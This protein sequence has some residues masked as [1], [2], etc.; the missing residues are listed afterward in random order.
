MKT[1]EVYVIDIFDVLLKSYVLEH[2]DIYQIINYKFKEIFP[3]RIALDFS[4]IRLDVE[5][6]L[7]QQ[8]ENYTIYDIYNRIE[9]DYSISQNTPGGGYRLLTYE[10][11]LLNN[12]YNIRDSVLKQIEKHK[13]YFISKK[14]YDKKII[15]ELLKN[16]KITNKLKIN[17]E[18]IIICNENSLEKTLKELNAIYKI[19][20]VTSYYNEIELCKKNNIDCHFYPKTTDIFMGYINESKVNNLGLINKKMNNEYIDLDNYTEIFGVRL[21]IALIASKLCD[22]EFFNINL[23]FNANNKIIGYYPFG[24]HLLSIVNWINN[25]AQ[26]NEKIVFLARDGFL[27]KKAFEIL[28]NKDTSYLHISRRSYIPLLIKQ[29]EDMFV[30][31]NYINIKHCSPKNIVSILRPILTKKHRLN[32]FENYNKIFENEKEYRKFIEKLMQYYDEKEYNNYLNI[33]KE[34]INSIVKDNSIIF[35]IGYSG[36]PEYL[37]SSLTCK[38]ISTCF[39]HSI[40][41]KSYE[42]SKFGNKYKLY[43]FYPYKPKYYG[44][45]RELL[46]SDTKP[47]CIAYKKNVK[48]IKIIFENQKLKKQEIKIIK[49]I[50]NSSLEFIKDFISIHKEYINYID[51]NNYYM[52]LPFEYFMHSIKKEEKEKIFGTQFEFEVNQNEYI[53]LIKEWEK[54]TKGV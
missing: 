19:K 10:I 24:M 5:Q 29:K 51:L 15:M 34:Y 9:E 38:K 3:E 52:S 18:D 49:E 16:K 47:S 30:I 33:F 28:S 11:Q 42:N 6:E 25:I 45:L 41:S 14:S 4:K 44:T 21:S 26:N 48:G 8:N 17:E 39:I 1:K 7:S 20:Y 36:F 31:K 53:N 22:D 40:N 54:N 50:Q 46:I 12:L 32:H 37:M 13:V 2:K 27:P 23:D 35:D 43:N